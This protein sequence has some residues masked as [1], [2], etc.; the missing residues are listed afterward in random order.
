MLGSCQEDDPE[1]VWAGPLLDFSSRH[2]DFRLWPGPETPAHSR[3]V[4]T[5]G[6]TR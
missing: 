5:K 4:L 3:S 2:E 1:S 6:G